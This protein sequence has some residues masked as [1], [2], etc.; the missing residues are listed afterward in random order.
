MRENIQRMSRFVGKFIRQLRGLTVFCL[1]VLAMN[2]LARKRGWRR[3]WRN[4]GSSGGE[5]IRPVPVMP[6]LGSGKGQFRAQPCRCFRP[7]GRYRGRL[8]LFRRHGA[9]R[10]CL[11]RTDAR[12]LAQKF[13]SLNSGQPNAVSRAWKSRGPKSGYP[14]HKDIPIFPKSASPPWPIGADGELFHNTLNKFRYFGRNG[15][16]G[17]RTPGVVEGKKWNLTNIN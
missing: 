8:R 1:A 3:A 4:P 12:P 14:L 2:I 7:P 13:S 15:I 11:E 6:L 10:Y 17:I 9:G 5:D 16:N